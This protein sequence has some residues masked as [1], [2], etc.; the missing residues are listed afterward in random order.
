MTFGLGLKIQ[1]E[2]VGPQEI[3]PVVIVLGGV[4]KVDIRP[5]GKSLAFGFGRTL[6]VFVQ[7]K[8]K[9]ARR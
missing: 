6:N 1:L 8:A 3:P 7:L 5:Y 2:F 4:G 9:Y